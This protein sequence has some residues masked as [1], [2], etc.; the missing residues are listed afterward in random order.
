MAS[1]TRYDREA[2][3]AF[4]RLAACAVLPVIALPERDL[5]VPLAETLLDAGL[6]CVEITFRTAGAP[7]AIEAIRRRVPDVLV[8]AGTVLTVDQAHEAID[9][10]AQ[11]IVAPGTNER[12]VEAV[13]GS[14]VAM[15]PGVATPSEIE[16]NLARG[17][18][19]MKL[20]PAEP[21]GGIAFLR[22]VAGP[23][24]GVRF[25]P[26]G[27]ITASNLADYLAQPNVL[28][29]GGSWIATGK[30]LAE[31]DWATIAEAARRAVSVARGTR[32]VA[33]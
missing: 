11:L 21:L 10:G 29:C 30:S 1:K 32:A 18:G 27:G 4:E 33:E 9:A 2:M 17:P 25:V 22:A 8:A 3:D 6:R 15:L 20:F 7:E 5:A 28:T 26:T 12:V 24:P 14:E 13:A 23:Y 19:V 16:R 31:R